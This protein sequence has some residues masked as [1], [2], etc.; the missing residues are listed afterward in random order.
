[1]K[2]GKKAKKGPFE[3]KGTLIFPDKHNWNQEVSSYGFKY[4][5]CLKLI[6]SDISKISGTFKKD[7]LNGDI[8]VTYFD[9]T[10]LKGHVKDG[11]LVGVYRF[12]GSDGISMNMTDAQTGIN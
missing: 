4:Q 12:F 1:M 7:V 2:G 8:S 3:G 10:V 5:K 9:G 6:S 11:I